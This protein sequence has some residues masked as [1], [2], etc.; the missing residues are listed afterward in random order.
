MKITIKLSD[1]VHSSLKELST[2]S[3]LTMSQIVEDALND[4][5]LEDLYDIKMADSRKDEPVEPFDKLVSQF[6]K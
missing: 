6:N 3:G 5:I 1:N 2:L 4:Q